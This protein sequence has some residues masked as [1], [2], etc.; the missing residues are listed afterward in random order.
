MKWCLKPY[1]TTKYKTTKENCYGVN[2]STNVHD[3][4]SPPEK[5]LCWTYSTILINSFDK[6]D[7]SYF[8]QVL[9]EEYK[10][11]DKEKNNRKKVLTKDLTYADYN[12]KSEN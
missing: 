9:E 2:I 7:N 11:K 10:R 12:Y 4:G 5:T 8:P 1:I 3:D 6:S